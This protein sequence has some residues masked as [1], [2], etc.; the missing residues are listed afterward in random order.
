[1][2]SLVMRLGL[3]SFSMLSLAVA[4]NEP[5]AETKGVELEA[6]ETKA[7]EIKATDRSEPKPAPSLGLVDRYA[8]AKRATMCVQA[9]QIAMAVEMSL[10]L[11]PGKC[12]TDVAALVEAKLLPRQPGGSPSWTIACKEAEVI[13][14]AP[15]PDQ[16]MGTTDDV[17]Q[18]GSQGTCG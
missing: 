7:A 2:L 14:S 16:R 5:P 10:A 17:V 12:P 6:A 13:V 9:Q 3:T 4:C 1:M 18:G 11:D 8:Q 15:G